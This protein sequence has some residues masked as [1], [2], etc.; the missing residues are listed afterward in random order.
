MSDSLSLISML[1]DKTDADFFERIKA[2]TSDVRKDKKGLLD[3]AS[4]YSEKHKEEIEKGTETAKLLLE[5]G[6]RQ[7]LSP[8]EAIGKW[9]VFIPTKKTPLLNLLYFLLKEDDGYGNNDIQVLR[10]QKYEGVDF[11]TLKKKMNGEYGGLTENE[12]EKEL[13]KV[14][15]MMEFIY[16]NVTTDTFMKIKKLKALSKSPNREEAFSA[17]TKCIEMCREYGLEFDRV[18]C[19]IK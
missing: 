19:N 3:A 4:T 11:E 10:E 13:E 14:P 18:P 16:D 6:K 15:E 7:G 5:N 1:N 2:K 8:E 17:Y 12:L 9:G